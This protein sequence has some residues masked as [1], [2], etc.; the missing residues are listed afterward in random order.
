[1]VV[2][3]RGQVPV[4]A[5]LFTDEHRTRTIL[6]VPA[7]AH[8]RSLSALERA[9]V[10][11]W[12]VPGSR[13]QVV[14]A[15]LLDMLAGEGCMHLLCE[16]GGGLAERLIRQE[17]VD[18]FLL[19]VAPLVMG[20]GISAVAGEGWPLKNAPRLRF[21]SVERVGP[22]VMIRAVPERGGR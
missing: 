9:G 1:M 17:L 16:G 6:A 22:D 12:R 5:R 21:I 19:I 7:G 15:R 4:N 14:L 2:S 8:G 11:V 3:G 10:K 20:A 18:E 13:Q